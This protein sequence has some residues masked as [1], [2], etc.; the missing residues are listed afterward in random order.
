MQTSIVSTKIGIP[1]LR[2]DI[3]ERAS[4]INRIKAGLNY[5]L[6]LV[7]A[8]AGYGK[9][10]LLAALIHQSD[11]IGLKAAWL[12]LDGSDNDRVNFWTHFI[13]ALQ[14]QNEHLGESSLQ[15]LGVPQ[16]VSIQPLLIDLI[17][18][19][20]AGETLVQPYILILDDYH[21]IEEPAIHQ[22]LTFLIEHLPWQLRLVISTRVDPPSPARMRARG[23]LSEFRAQDMRFTEEEIHTFFNG[24]MKLGLSSE[25]IRALDTRTEGW[26]AGLQMAAISMT[27]QKNLASF[28]TTFTGTHRHI[29]DFLTEEVLNHQTA[30]TRS[31][32]L[33]TSILGR[34]CGPLCDAVTGRHDAQA[35]LDLLDNAN[36][37]IV[38]LDD[39]REWY[40]YHHL[41]SSMLN[42]RLKQLYPERV[43]DL[44]TKAA[45]WYM[46][47][48]F[49]DEAISHA[50]ASGDF[51]LAVRFMEFASPMAIFNS[52]IGAMLN[53][54]RM[55]PEDILCKH[56]CS[57]VFYAS[58]LARSGKMEAAENWLKKSEGK[59]ILAPTKV[60]AMIVQALIYISQQRDQTVIEFLYQ[61]IN[62]NDPQTG[63]L[64]PGV[65]T[66]I[67]QCLKLYAIILLSQAQATQGHLRQAGETCQEVLNQVKDSFTDTPVRSIV[68]FLHERLAIVEYELND[69]QGATQHITEAARLS[70]GANNKELQACCS[71]IQALIH[72]ARGETQEALNFA[73][74]MERTSFEG[75]ISGRSISI[76][77]LRVRM[78]FAQGNIRGVTQS[79]SLQESTCGVFEP[80]ASLTFPQNTLDM[81]SAY[82]NVAEGKYTEAD[83]SLEKLQTDAEK[84]GR[85][86]NLIEILLLRA[87]ATRSR[88]KIAEAVDL[89]RRALVLAEPE[90]YVRIFIDL[91]PPMAGLLKEAASKVAF[92]DYI[93]KLLEEYEKKGHHTQALAYQPLIEPLSSRE[94]EI[95]KLIATD[96]SNEEIAHKLFL[97]VG[98]IKAHAHNIYTKLGVTSRLQAINRARDLN[99]L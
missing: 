40:R 88:G 12:S 73:G 60:L 52:E 20:S 80:C 61:I 24:I 14:T 4:L 17:N 31:F 22:D 75:D 55:L 27:K 38:P 68:G 84:A 49:I 21:L 51:E 62:W 3:V 16:L 93:Q 46:Q 50:I 74:E 53:R 32:L 59:Q 7:S 30:E 98:T 35:T 37:F 9:T 1:R 89:L 63:T 71:I 11:S 18:E 64:L 72:Q 91:G 13:S 19:I 76:L 90:G 83:A 29:F 34:L 82:L 54:F 96:L 23:Q 47:N 57:C 25:E 87:L 99:L 70:E 15:M 78:W 67:I 5:P 33:E 69:L 45:S 8:P 65:P 28:I 81:S 6:T 36:L 95:L 2:A 58:A 41:F 48:G 86:G 42:S 85:N 94:I 79:L 97:T 39:E 77:P 10:T 92:S 66:Q 56:P 43:T 44:Q 26:I